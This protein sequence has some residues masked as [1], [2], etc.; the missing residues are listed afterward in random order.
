M[1]PAP[2]R[3]V[4]AKPV[5]I[6][7]V[8]VIIIV[9]VSGLPGVVLVPVEEEEEEEEAE[10]VIDEALEVLLERTTRLIVVVSRWDITGRGSTGAMFPA[11]P[12]PVYVKRLSVG[13][14]SAVR[15]VVDGM[16]IM[17]PV[18]GSNKM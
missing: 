15:W 12:R 14:A 5:I 18:S 9:G 13:H 8:V 6:V 10:D 16:V 17:K 4:D 7:V 11:P 3:P 2:P 1:L